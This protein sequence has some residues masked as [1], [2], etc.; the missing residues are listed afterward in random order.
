VLGHAFDKAG[1]YQPVTVLLFAAPL[2][3]AALLQLVLP[4]YPAAALQMGEA[5]TVLEVAMESAS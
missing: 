5:T 2:L 4:K 1:S 3:V